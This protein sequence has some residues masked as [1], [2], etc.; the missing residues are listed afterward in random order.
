MT[1]VYERR[2]VNAD[3]AT[4]YKKKEDGRHESLT[5]QT[6]C[7]RQSCPNPERGHILTGFSL[8]DSPYGILLTGFSLRGHMAEYSRHQRLWHSLFQRHGHAPQRRIMQVWESLR[9]FDQSNS[10]EFSLPFYYT[11]LFLILSSTSKSVSCS[12]LLVL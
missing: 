2:P 12:F 9:K 8:R 5:G 11:I 3:G 4:V 7:P 6:I 1:G 10:Y